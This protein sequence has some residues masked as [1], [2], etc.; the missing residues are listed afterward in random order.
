M[1]AGVAS[2]ECQ[3]NQVYR[4]LLNHYGPQH[5]WPGDTAFEVMVG[6]ILTQNTAWRNVEAAINNLKRA[7]LLAADEIINCPDTELAQLL[8]PAGYFNIKTTRLKNLCMLLHNAGF[9]RLQEMPT[10]ELRQQL[11]A[12]NGV[13]PET[14]DA[15][16]LY[17]FQRPVFVIDAYTRR[18]FSRFGLVS[19]NEDYEALRARFE[20]ALDATAAIYNEYHA[21]IVQHAKH[22]CRVKP[23]CDRC[24]LCPDCE[25]VTK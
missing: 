5:W 21:L 4:S 18:I 1:S 6:A 22:A 13:G 16:L 11:L 9:K 24:I 19:G 20:V 2:P 7:D 10:R 12:V 3:F 14:A 15:I 8:R 17:A 23:E 25:Y